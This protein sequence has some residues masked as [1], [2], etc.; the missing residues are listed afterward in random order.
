MRIF[1]QCTASAFKALLPS[2]ALARLSESAAIKLASK[3]N[4]APAAFS[5][6]TATTGQHGNV[7]IDKE[8]D[9]TCE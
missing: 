9:V 8:T 2:S 6:L 3:S 4:P 7:A 1:P 5:S